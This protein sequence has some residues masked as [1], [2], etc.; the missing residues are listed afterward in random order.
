[1]ARKPKRK[2][3]A[4]GPGLP[5][6]EDILAFVETSET[7]VGKREIARH[8]GIR[9]PKKIALKRLLAE[10]ADD[11]LVAGNRKELRRK[12]GLPPVTVLEVTGADSNGDLVAEPVQ[13]NAD[14]GPKPKALIT[15]KSSDK[16]AVQIGQGDRLLAQ[17][18]LLTASDRD[19]VDAGIRYRATPI[20]RLPR[21][22]RQLLGIFRKSAN[23]G[24]SIEPIDRKMLKSWSVKQHDAGETKDGDLVRFELLRR[25][26]HSLAQARIVESLGNPDAQQQISLIAVH[27]H[28][29]PDTFPESVIASLGQ[30][31]EPSLKGRD[32]LRQTPLITIDPADARDHDDAVYAAHDDDKKNPGG[33]IVIVA[34]ADVAHYVHP[35][36]KLDREARKRAN[37]VYFPDRV[38]PMLPERISN[39]LCSLRQN[40]E[41]PCLAVK[42]VFSKD[43]RKLR[44]AFTR[45][46]MRSHLKL[47]YSEAQAAFDGK[48]DPAHAGFIDDVLKPLWQAYKVVAKARDKR[49][50]LALDL[51]ERK[52]IL[53]EEG[54]V[55]RIIIPDRLE[56][57]RL[58]EEFMIQANV[59]AAETLE[60][61]RQKLVY[62]VHD[63]PSREKL[64]ALAE[65]L[66]TLDIPAPKTGDIKPSD[67][68][69]ILKQAEKLPSPDMVHE[70]IL[71]SQAQAVYAPDNGG[72]FG[73]N[74]RR[75]AHFT[76]PIRRYADLIVHRALIRALDLGTDGLTDE[77]IENLPD[78]AQSISD[79][80]RR[81]MAAER[82]TIDR[83]IAAHLAD[84]INATFKAR[85]S[86]VTA[87]GLFVRLS[88][89]GADGFVPISTLDSDYYEFDEPAMALVG[90]RTGQTYRLGDTVEVRLVEAIPT[91]GAMRFEMISAGKKGRPLA[92]KSTRPGRPRPKKPFKRRRR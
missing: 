9:G 59:A 35:G 76:S 13:W 32:D 91:A 77:E 3:A 55:D 64:K 70:M 41:R 22:Q 90:R 12:G 56:A 60:K 47:S 62:R 68:N 25:A 65:F 71:R 85:I 74:L 16:R 44:H 57:H 54:Q 52:I 88:E 27:A 53:N 30:L 10:M 36:S 66:E 72:H 6:R 4:A 63:A 7:K 80:E 46:M 42:M 34:I 39:D 33:F 73:L 28:G 61:H 1:V 5:S 58:I 92:R 29:L 51:P 49:A 48:A 75:Y 14:E 26:R 31:K 82:E 21:D 23:G 17:M 38:V 86:G 43:G 2:S 50:P 18:T 69:Y 20:R 89:T 78:I 11:G 45:A 24:G 40:E 37:S 79:I 67:F 87:V 15:T 81:A 83:L 8:F 19:D 84:R